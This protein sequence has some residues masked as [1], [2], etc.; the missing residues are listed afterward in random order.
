MLILR[1]GD[2]VALFVDLADLAAG[3]DPDVMPVGQ[4]AGVVGVPLGGEGED[5]FAFAGDFEDLSDTS[6]RR[7]CRWARR[8]TLVGAMPACFQ[9]MTPRGI[10]L[11]DHGCRA[12]RRSGVGR[13]GATGRRSGFGLVT[14]Q[15]MSPAGLHFVRRGRRRRGA[16]SSTTR[17]KPRA[18]S[19]RRN[20][21]QSIFA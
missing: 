8:W 10:H 7:C 1:F 4:F 9:P 17:V 15:R 11:V 19:S 16:D 14:C 2:R 18:C 5:G 12:N 6:R 21:F 3:V 13:R 20:D